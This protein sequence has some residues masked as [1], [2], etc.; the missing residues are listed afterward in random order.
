MNLLMVFFIYEPLSVQIIRLLRLH[1]KW[2]YEEF[3]ADLNPSGASI[4]LVSAQTLKKKKITF[5]PV[6]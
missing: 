5:N 1:F 6:F 4:N 3:K 2:L